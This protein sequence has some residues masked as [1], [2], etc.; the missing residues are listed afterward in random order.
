MAFQKYQIQV[1]MYYMSEENQGW[2]K[3]EVRTN[4]KYGGSI[5]LM[6]SQTLDFLYRVFSEL[7]GEGFVHN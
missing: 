3:I 1:S 2:K 5:T 7:I 4:E 6:N